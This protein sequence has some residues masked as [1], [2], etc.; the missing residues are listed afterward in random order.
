[1]SGIQAAFL[2]LTMWCAF[3]PSLMGATTRIGYSSFDGTQTPGWIAREAGLFAKHGLNVELVF[4]AG[5]RAIVPLIAGDTPIATVAGPSAIAARLG[6]SSWPKYEPTARTT[7]QE[8]FPDVIIIAHIFD[9]LVSSLMVTPDVRSVADLRGKRLGA[10]RFGPATELPLLHLLRQEGIDPMKDV[11]IVQIGSQA[12]MLVALRAGSIQGAMLALPAAADAKKLG[13]VKLIDMARLGIEYPQTVIAT[14]ERFLRGRR[15]AVLRFTRAYVEAINRFVND[16]EFSLKV[17]AKY[18]HI[19]SRS[20]LERMYDGHVKYV[21]H[22]PAPT[23]RSIKNVLE[24]LVTRDWRALGY[25]PDDYVN[26]S[27]IVELEREGLFQHIW[28]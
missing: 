12:E 6:S 8:V 13:M 27:V 22:I 24:Q 5:D 2:L 14:T 7:K 15:D 28:R 17:M 25:P 1:M 21:K 18:S 4:T 20:T 9:S 26:G 23:P 3:A 10:S 19:Q 16:R 11:T